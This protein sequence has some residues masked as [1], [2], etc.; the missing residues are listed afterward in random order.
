MSMRMRRT[1]RIE[2]KATAMT[3]TTTV[4]GLRS[5]ARMSHMLMASLRHRAQDFEK[6]IDVALGDGESTEGAPGIQPG[7]R[8]IGFGP[9]Q[10]ALRLS[11]FHYIGQSCLVSCACLRFAVACRLQLGWG[12]LGN[13]DCSLKPRLCLG[14]LRREVLQRLLVARGLGPL[15]GFG[16]LFA[17][18]SREYVEHRKRGGQTGRPVFS[19]QVQARGPSGKAAVE[20]GAGAPPTD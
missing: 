4:I 18:A 17:R 10:Q 1:A 8:I 16:N 2:H 3:R 20:V 5:A 14:S 12:G 6:W 7:D 13:S 19:L 11:Y 9:H 15:V